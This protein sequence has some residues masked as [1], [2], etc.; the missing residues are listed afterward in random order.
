MSKRVADDSESA[1][2]D[3]RI[4]KL[5]RLRER[6]EELL[7]RL[8]GTALCNGCEEYFHEDDVDEDGCE[9]CGNEFCEP[10]Q[11]KM[12]TACHGCDKRMCTQCVIQCVVPGCEWHGCYDCMAWNV[13]EEFEC[14]HNTVCPGH[15]D[16]CIL[17]LK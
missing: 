4:T 16:P 1:P 6:Y 12:D 2:L 14:D 9:E 8:P 5:T 13:V 10:C 17:C 7:E 3:E 11:E 15:G